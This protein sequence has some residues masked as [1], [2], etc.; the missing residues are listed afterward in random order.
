MRQFQDHIR[1]KWKEHNP[2]RKVGRMRLLL[3][4]SAA[5]AVG[6][7]MPDMRRKQMNGLSNKSNETVLNRAQANAADAVLDLI[8]DA[9]QRAR[10]WIERTLRNPPRT[11][12]LHTMTEAQ[13]IAARKAV[14]ELEVTLT[15]VLDLEKAG[16]FTGARTAWR[17]RSPCPY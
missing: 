11:A 1:R 14:T 10:H 15:K 5:P 17:L 2:S 12:P 16:D 4:R 3:A 13:E 9:V 6:A 8:E 7:I